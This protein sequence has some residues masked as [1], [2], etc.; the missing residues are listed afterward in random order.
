MALAC[1]NPLPLFF[2]LVLVTFSASANTLQQARDKQDIP[3]L[4][5]IAGEAAKLR[6][7]QP[8]DAEASYQLAKVQST[9]AE[10]AME[11]RDKGQARVAV[12]A[13]MPAAEKAISQKP[14]RAEYH[15]ILGTLCGQAAAAVGGLGALKYGKCAL[16]EVN[17]AIQLDPK[18]SLN[19]LSHGVGNYY[20]PTAL[21]GGLELAIQDFKKALA[22][23]AKSADAHL[24]MGLALRKT[25]Q[26]A[27]AEGEFRKALAL[28]PERAFTQKQ[29][30][31][32]P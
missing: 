29:L 10:V 2:A 12:E 28:N 23:D 7:A 5:R 18:S 27:Q 32:T 1:V 6:A 17:K 25:N 13:G 26:I 16:E 15:R 30:A 8:N 31:K 9:L 14:D 24:W 4:T 22:L 11:L 19:Y 3:T 21:G 20:L